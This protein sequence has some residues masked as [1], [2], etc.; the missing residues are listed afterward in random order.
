MYFC[1]SKG[2]DQ[3]TFFKMLTLV[4]HHSSLIIYN[5]YTTWCRL[6]NPKMLYILLQRP[7]KSDHVLNH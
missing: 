1:S 7:V 5:N 2:W 3:F 4:H 6:K